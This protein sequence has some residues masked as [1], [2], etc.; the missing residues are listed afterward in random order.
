MSAE[1]EQVEAVLREF[2][3]ESALW[4][5]LDRTKLAAALIEARAERDATKKAWQNADTT[6]QALS[7]NA[8]YI[9]V[10]GL[11][12]GEHTVRSWL[13]RMRVFEEEN[14]TLRTDI[15]AYRDALGYGYDTEYP[16]KLS[17]G[18]MVVNREAQQFTAEWHR[19]RAQADTLRTQLAA[20]RVVTDAAKVAVNYI[21]D[22]V[23]A[24][25]GLKCREPNCQSCCME[26]DAEAHVQKAREARA[27]LTAALSEAP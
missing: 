23:V 11:R 9:D 4:P 7:I 21:I 14:D 26:D 27:A 1:R 10:D 18:S 24:C 16:A 19:A 6:A 13:E 3:F 17:D 2:S 12:V 22:D 25:C 15:Q 5:S 8:G 20:A